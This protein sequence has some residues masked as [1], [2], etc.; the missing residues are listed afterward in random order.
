MTFKKPQIL[1]FILP[2]MIIACATDTGI[3]DFDR[4]SMSWLVLPV[5]GETMVFQ[6]KTSPQYPADQPEAESVRRQW[7][8][9]WLQRRALCPSGYE[10]T[11]GPRPFLPHEDNPHRANL[12]YEL[13]CAS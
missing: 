4:H 8:S 1:W 11:D 12:R 7:I 6:V 2:W 5:S 9:T 3:S 13:K 10:V